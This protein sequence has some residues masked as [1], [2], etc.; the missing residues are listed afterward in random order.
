MIDRRHLNIRTAA[1]G[2]SVLVALGAGAAFATDP[3]PSVDPEPDPRLAALERR[4]TALAAEL[5]R[6]NAQSA[7]RWATY[8]AQYAARQAE[9]ARVTAANDR[10]SAAN[11]DAAAAASASAS[12]P[13]AAPAPVTYVPAAPVASSGSS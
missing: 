8:R 10:T 12:A 4:E 5:R 9:I 3:F 1:I 7:R 13:V 6:A 2:A 11:A